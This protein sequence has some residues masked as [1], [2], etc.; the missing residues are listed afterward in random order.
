MAEEM[1]GAS[2]KSILIALGI[3]ATATIFGSAL[4]A[5]NAAQIIGF[6]SLVCVSLL[7]LLQ[8]IRNSA[9]LDVAAQKVDVAA[10]KTEEVKQA[11]AKSDKKVEEVKQ[12]LL[13]SDK[14]TDVQMADLAKVATATHTLVNN[15][16]A[17]QLKISATALRQVA[18]LMKASSTSGW[19]EA[20]KAA[21]DADALLAD[22]EAKQD[23]VDAVTEKL[24]G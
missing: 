3:V 18:N 17:I 11:L 19:Q 15:K 2:Q 20:E 9:K 21:G 12:A 4:S 14:K 1:N 8:Q 13:V 6:G 22:H 7:G 23:K 5:P 16:M 10:V 24:S